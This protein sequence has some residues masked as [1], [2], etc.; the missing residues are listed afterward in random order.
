M[1]KNRV[2][3][4]CKSMIINTDIKRAGILPISHPMSDLAVKVF[5]KIISKC[6]MSYPCMGAEEIYSLLK[7]KAFV[8]FL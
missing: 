3:I 6:G 5:S 8:R 4:Y 7:L 2:M 1:S